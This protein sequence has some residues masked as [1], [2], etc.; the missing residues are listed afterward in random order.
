M[1][2]AGRVYDGEI[3]DAYLELA[4]N[5][6]TDINAVFEIL[7]G[8]DTVKAKHAL[9]GDAKD[10]S[11]EVMMA[12]DAWPEVEDI[13]SAAGQKCRVWVGE[14]MGRKYGRLNVG[15]SGSDDPE[16]LKAA[17]KKLKGGGVEPDVPF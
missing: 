16:A 8:E 2:E 9:F 12:F 1:L 6:D 4:Y 3:I 10:R 11:I 7:I 15:A 14:Y 13:V 5:S 17:I